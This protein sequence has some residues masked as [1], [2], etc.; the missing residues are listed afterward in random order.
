[1]SSGSSSDLQQTRAQTPCD[2]GD[3]AVLEEQLSATYGQLE[4]RVVELSGQ[5]A[6]ASAQRMQELAE[7]E[8]LAHRLQSLLDVLPGGV[9]VIDTSGHVREANPVACALL[10]EPLVG[11]LW[12][13]V[14]ARDFAPRKDDGHEVSTRS[15]KRLSIAIRSLRGEPG[16]LIL[17]TD[18]TE[19]RRLQDQVSH[20]TRLSALGRMVASLAHQI[21]TPLSTALIYASHLAEKKLAVEQQQR[22]AGK[23]KERLLE[24]E[25]QVRDMLV[26]ARGDLPLQDHLSAVQ[27]FDALRASSQTLLEGVNVRW[28]CDVRSQPLLCNRDTLVGALCN[29]IE[30]ALQAS[31]SRQRLKVHFYQRDTVLHIAISDAGEGIAAALLR[32]LGEPFLTTKVTGTGLGLSVVQS[33]VK[34]HRGGFSLRS[35]QGFGTCAKVSLPLLLGESAR[36][37][38]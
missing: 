35:R 10:G 5:L 26:F 11:L 34:A 9:I 30:N 23:L 13:E 38:H 33:V 18:L 1:M 12:R 4:A 36:G 37:M 15:G 6:A 19:T 17:L 27:L 25:C 31:S 14:I 7:K 3:I 20:N 24:L 2:V 16:Q 28:Q 8:R 22:F 21:R 32:R 29:L